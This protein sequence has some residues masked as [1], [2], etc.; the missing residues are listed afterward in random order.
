MGSAASTPKKT[1][2]AILGTDEPAGKALPEYV[3]NLVKGWSSPKFWGRSPVTSSSLE[4]MDTD[5]MMRQTNPRSVMRRTQM[6]HAKCS[7][8]CTFYE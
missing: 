7:I 3:R 2:T 8:Q 5:A 6:F 4:A 1:F